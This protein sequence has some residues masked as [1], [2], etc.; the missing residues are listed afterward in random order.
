M[1]YLS[2]VI[3]SFLA[4]SVNSQEL[5]FNAT[6]RLVEP[7]LNNEI[8]P[9]NIVEITYT[10]DKK[11]VELNRTWKI[12]ESSVPTKGWDFVKGYTANSKNKIQL[13]FTKV[14]NYSIEL[15]VETDTL[16]DEETF[17]GEYS[18]FITV[19]SLFPE[20]AA[21]YAQKPNPSYMKLV[22][23]ASE[24]VVKP[25]YVTDPT[26]NLFLAKGMLGLAKGLESTPKIDR[27]TA[28]SECVASYVAA[29]ELDLNGVL[30]DDEH[31]RFINELE[32]YLF[33]NNIK[34]YADFEPGTDSYDNFSE[35]VDYYS[36]VSSIPFSATILQAYIVL[37][38]G[39]AGEAVA[40]WKSEIAAMKDYKI[41]G[42][43]TTYGYKVKDADSVEAIFSTIDIQ[44]LKMGVTKSVD[45]LIKLKGE[46][47]LL[48]CELLASVEPFLR[49][50][51]GFLS[52]YNTQM[53]V[54]SCK[55]GN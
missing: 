14:G 9:E 18:D 27:E 4:F 45:E 37:K 10:P 44:I 51:R 24:Y 22:E 31:Q 54:L 43:E 32:S 19:R 5:T 49:D 29:K 47:G 36:E 53:K 8:K 17:I 2:I 12:N 21:L 35:Y 15:E 55:S 11:I 7:V 33:D 13:V 1:N 40:M 52:Y 25:K 48:A 23:K 38:D 16:T 20:L 6:R 41:L 34:E 26:P 42:K 28:M 50:D 3:I 46:N 39:S 30:F